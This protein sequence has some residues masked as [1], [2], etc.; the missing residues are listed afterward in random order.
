MDKVT[1]SIIIPVYNSE[2]H[3]DKCLASIIRQDMSSYEVILVDDGSIDSSPLICDRFS[4][5][6]ARFRTI[7]KKNGG[8]SSARNAGINLAQGEF[9]LFVDSD[10][11]LAEGALSHL[12]SCISSHPDIV[13]GGFNV[14]QEEI[15]ND[16]ISSSSSAFYSKDDLGNFFD[17]TMMAYGQLYRGPWAK[18]FRLSLIRKHAL[19]FNENLSYAEDKLFVYQYLACVSSAASVNLPVY[20]YYRRA[21]TLS[22]GKTDEKRARQLIAVTPLCASAMKDLIDKSGT[23][24]S[25]RTV[26]H[27]DLVCCDLMR[28]LRF[29]LKR[30]TGLMSEENLRMLYSVMDNDSLTR[31]FERRVPGQ[32]LNT[33]LYKAGNLSLSV[34][35]YRVSSFISSAFHA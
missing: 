1:V 4:S 10:D 32:I 2:Q 19:R 25:L 28:I 20:E 12:T 13:V 24:R 3:L 23:T 6:D 26:Y 5:T 14:Y 15:L 8:V 30:K 9:V 33:L 11:A 31:I 7:H 35:V 18:L 16:C 27:N 29:F 22:G 34:F 17:D 21:G